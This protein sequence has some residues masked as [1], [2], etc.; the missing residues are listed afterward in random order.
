MSSGELETK[1]SGD[2]YWSK[3]DVRHVVRPAFPRARPLV[4]SSARPHRYRPR[5]RPRRCFHLSAIRIRRAEPLTSLSV[6]VRP[7]TLNH[8]PRPRR[9]PTG[10]PREAKEGDPRE[11]PADQ[12]P[13]RPGLDHLPADLRRR[14][15]AARVRVLPRPERLHARADP[16]RVR[17]RRLRHRQSLP[18]EPRAEP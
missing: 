4:A 7:L 11:V 1:K 6:D 13:V 16:M 17:H 9:D 2:F 5:G 12:G 15:R 10:A 18:G 14:R 8:L 3:D